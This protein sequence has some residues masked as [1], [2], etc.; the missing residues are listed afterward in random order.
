MKTGFPLNNRPKR[1]ENTTSRH[2]A[3]I[4]SSFPRYPT[5]HTQIACLYILSPH[6]ELPP[7]RRKEKMI[8]I[9]AMLHTWATCDRMDIGFSLIIIG[10]NDPRIHLTETT[11]QM[12]SFQ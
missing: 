12:I 9:R 10:L 6:D 3:S 5:Y 1:A 7:K 8:K 11:H 4:Q 2:Q